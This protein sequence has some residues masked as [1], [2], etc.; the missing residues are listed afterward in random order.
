[1]SQIEFA[2]IFRIPLGTLR[3]WE[4]HRR[5]PDQAAQAYFEVIGREPGAVRRTLKAGARA[6]A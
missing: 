2:K 4:Q 3:D 6:A 1:M 5:D